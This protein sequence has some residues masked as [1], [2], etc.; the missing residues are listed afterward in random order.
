MLKNS[1]MVLLFS[2]F[3]FTLSYSEEE[4]EIVAKP[5]SVQSGIEAGQIVNG[6]EEQNVKTP[7]LMQGQ[8]QTRLSVWLTQEVIIKKRL[9]FKMGVGGLFW[10]PCPENP[11]N[12][13]DYVTK[14][15]PG[16][17]QATGIYK[18][19]ALDNPFLELQFGYFPFKY[20]NEA[21][22]LG[23]Y[24]L[25]SGC[26]PG[27]LMGGNWN[28]IGD[29]LYRVMGIR[30]TNYVLDGNIKHH[31][32]LA[33]ER[34]VAP[35]YDL[36]PSIIGDYSLLN[37]I[38]NLGVGITFNHLIAANE[39]KTTPQF[40]N[41]QK[42]ANRYYDGHALASTTPLDSVNAS[43]YTFRGIKLMGRLTIDPKPIFSTTIFGKEDLK[44]FAEAAVLGVKNYPY[45]Y[46][47]I[48]K[49]IPVMFGINLPF[50]KLLDICA[51]QLEWYGSEWENTL[52]G[53]LLNQVPLPTISI[54]P[55]NPEAVLDDSTIY[56]DHP[57][58]AIYPQYKTFREL[59]STDNWKWSIYMKRNF[60][61]YFSLMLQMANDHLRTKWA[62]GR[63]Q[64]VTATRGN[65]KPFMFFQK[66][67]YFMFRLQYG[68]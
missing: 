58:S 4:S 65:D 37:K 55:D 41:T 47:D 19:G 8:W 59:W 16:I 5:L 49:R 40:S 1:F 20:N 12:A 6:R 64:Y 62:S 10:Y 29:A 14:F 39:K 56:M 67:W 9:T 43:Y 36:S 46:N 24:L 54:S 23:E 21:T 26:Y 45:Y 57:V 7:N 34:D 48:S 53:P 60:G 30:L 31:I 17:S 38:I 22:N 3:L 15:G 27:Y 61:K 28:F 68:L 2:L 18:W 63:P 11:G 35:M 13:D 33:M 32:I 44:L 50:F 25:R 52:E 51:I 66:D 42:L